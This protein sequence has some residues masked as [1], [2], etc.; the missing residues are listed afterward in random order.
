ML[1]LISDAFDSSLPDKL[2]LDRSQ[3]G[4]IGGIDSLDAHQMFAL[5]IPQGKQTGV[6]RP[7]PHR[8]LCVPAQLPD[9]DGAGA[10]VAFP[11]A[12]LGTRQPTI[13]PQE[14]QNHRAGM[15]G[16]L[17][18]GIVQYETYRSTH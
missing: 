9:Q 12:F 6:D 13:G 16:T 7:V 8:S 10:A 1:I 17:N 5:Q 11:A 2:A 14:I 4:R 18:R 3:D 15:Q